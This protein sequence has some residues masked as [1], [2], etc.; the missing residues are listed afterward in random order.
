MPGGPS[1][2]D[3]MFAGEGEGQGGKPPG[4]TAMPCSNKHAK[5]ITQDL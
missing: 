4:K 3:E 5:G 2:V 1:A